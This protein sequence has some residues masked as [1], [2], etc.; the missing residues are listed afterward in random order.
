MNQVP[1]VIEKVTGNEILHESSTCGHWK[2]KVMEYYMNQVHVVI[3]KVTVNEILHETSTCGHCSQA[4][5]HN[6]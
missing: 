6:R 2:L 3:E 1:V 5:H 4:C